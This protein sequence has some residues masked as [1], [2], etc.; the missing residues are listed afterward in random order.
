M[1]A[2]DPRPVLSHA[3]VTNPS[4]TATL[5]TEICGQRLSTARA[6]NE[7]RRRSK[8]PSRPTAAAASRGNVVLFCGGGNHARTPGLPGGAEGIQTDGHRGLT[9]FGSRDLPRISEVATGMEAVNYEALF[10]RMSQ[11]PLAFVPI[12]SNGHDVLMGA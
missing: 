12:Q 3:H 10:A 8:R 11:I 1:L 5:E 2:F 6:A 4:Q 7:P 9:P